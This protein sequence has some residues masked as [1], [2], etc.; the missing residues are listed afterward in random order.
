MAHCHGRGTARRGKVIPYTYKDSLQ[1]AERTG[2]VNGMACQKGMVQQFVQEVYAGQASWSL[3]ETFLLVSTWW[4]LGMAE[5]QKQKHRQGTL[6]PIL[7]TDACTQTDFLWRKKAAQTFSSVDPQNL[8]VNHRT[9]VGDEC[10]EWRCARLDDVL[11]QL[12][13]LRQE[14]S[15]LRCIQQSKMLRITWLCKQSEIQT[16]VSNQGWKISRLLTWQR[17]DMSKMRGAGPLCLLG[18]QG[19]AFLPLPVVP[20]SHWLTDFNLWYERKKKLWI[21]VWN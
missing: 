2:G 15:G 12:A 4:P 10:H 7:W 19:E 1:E 21:A 6:Y 9:K 18:A 11:E 16:L 17:I 13:R 5:R 14:V 20:K 8:E 3:G